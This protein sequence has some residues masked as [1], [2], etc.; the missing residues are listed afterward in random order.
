[1]IL[2]FI[3]DLNNNYLL[4]SSVYFLTLS[5]LPRPLPAF[6]LPFCTVSHPLHLLISLYVFLC[7]QLMAIDAIQEGYLSMLRPLVS[8]MLRVMLCYVMLCYVMLCYVMLCYVMLCYVMSCYSISPCLLR[9]L[10]PFIPLS[11]A[12]VFMCS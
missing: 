3:C 6:L 2:V 5:Y 11:Y 4:T 9:C 10:S 8:S 7:L 1:M 12:Y